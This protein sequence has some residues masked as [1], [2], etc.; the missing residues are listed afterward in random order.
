MISFL[1][2]S[3]RQGVVTF[4]IILG[5]I[6]F[7]LMWGHPAFR[8]IIRYLPKSWQRWLIA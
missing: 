8:V 5:L 6:A 3:V 4:F 7:R 2:V 1:L